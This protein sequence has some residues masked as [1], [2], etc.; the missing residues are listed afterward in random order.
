[1]VN[2]FSRQPQVFDDVARAIAG[3][4]AMQAAIV[5]YGAT[6]V[7]QM[8]QALQSRDVIGQAKGILMQR[9]GIDARAAFDKLVRA[10]QETN[11]KLADIAR[12]LANDV[13]RSPTA[14]PDNHPRPAVNSH[15][16]F[17]EEPRDHPRSP[18]A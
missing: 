8:E 13:V 12:W 14:Q 4:F 3:G 16:R 15:P 17:H 2:I 9:D 7:A 1:V 10:S 18:R 11:M 5:V 6:R